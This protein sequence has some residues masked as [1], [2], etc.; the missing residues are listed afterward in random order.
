MHEDK[1]FRSLAEMM[2]QMVYVYGRNGEPLFFNQRFLNY[3]GLSLEGA[4]AQSTP[5]IVHDDDYPLLIRHWEKSIST[6]EPFEFEMRMRRASDGSYRWHLSRAAPSRDADGKIE[7]WYGTLTDIDDHKRTVDALAMLA[8][9]SNRFSSTLGV[10]QTLD[11]LAQTAIETFADW[12]SIYTFDE[13]NELQVAAFAHKDP[14]RITWAEELIREF[15]L[16]ADEPTSLVARGADA[17]LFPE[18]TDELLR[19]GA[20]D[21]RHYELVSRLG[22]RSV[23]ILPLRARGEALGAISLISAE[24]GRSFTDADLTI[25][26][27]LAQRAALTYD[28]ARVIERLS[29][30]EERFRTLVESI[31]PMVWISRGDDGAIEYVNARWREYFNLTLEESAGWLM[32]DY[33]HPEDFER[34]NDSWKTSLRTG[35]TYEI[36]Y[37]L[38][39]SDGTYH[40][41]LARGIPVVSKDGTILQWFG[42]T[43]N[44]DAQQLALE[45]TQRAVD[46]L[47]EAFIP[48]ELPQTPF[49]RFDAAYLPAENEARVGGDWYDAFVLDD[50][51]VVFSIGDVAGHGLEAAVVMANIRQAVLGASVDTPDPAGVLGKVNR[52]VC[53]QHSMLAS[54]I[55]GFIRDGRVSYSSAGHPPAVLADATAARLLPHGGLPLGVDQNANY[56]NVEFSPAVGNMLVLYTDGLT[57][58]RRLVTEAEELLLE[59]SRNAAASTSSAA[60]IRDEVL[61]DAVASDDVA[62]MTLRF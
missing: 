16:Q 62:I 45:R 58:A 56:S 29:L 61:G 52:I 44:I 36:D 21:D 35:Q 34:A 50:G 26:Q 12:C 7:R 39:R 48:R 28:A 41:F 18:I 59:A 13:H 53:F 3:T 54:A 20:Q 46:T 33:V 19:A 14:E 47:Q 24:S 32:R 9:A 60:H 6:G 30:S 49:V 17:M 1:P 22:L 40:W 43:T 37:R 42:S 25:A 8:D 51:T 38:R 55:V 27:A 2:P 31:A 5:S 11:L 10:R 57:E 4:L 23:M 15:P